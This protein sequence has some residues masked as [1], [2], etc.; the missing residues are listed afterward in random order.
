MI[1]HKHHI[2]PKHAGGT[3]DSSNIIELTI[4]EHAEAHKILY[5]KYGR[6]EDKLAWLGLSG[7]IGKDEIL[8]IIAMSQ[9]GKKKPNG[10][11][12]KISTFRKKFRYSEESKLKMSLAKKGKKISKEHK[13]KIGLS[14]KGKKQPES[15]KQKVKESLQQKW[16]VTSPNGLSKYIV[17]LS[18]FCRENLLDQGNMV[19]VSKG[20]IKKHKGWTC[21][22]VI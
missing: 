2:V 13:E 3:D 17:N 11:S 5:E 8:K 15:Q 16:V 12:E 1:K 10:F 22:K 21:S 6:I 19:K 14:N 20:I 7:Q 4:E 18:E 9:K